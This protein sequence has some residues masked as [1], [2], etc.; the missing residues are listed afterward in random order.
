MA[1]LLMTNIQIMITEISDYEL[2][3]LG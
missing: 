3:Y 2:C 1:F